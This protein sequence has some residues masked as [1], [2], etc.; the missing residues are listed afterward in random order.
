MSL[1]YGLK[2]LSILGGYIA[3]SDRGRVSPRLLKINQAWR[4]PRQ[5]HQLSC[6]SPQK[7]E[8]Q[9]ASR[10]L[11]TGSRSYQIN[12]DLS[13]PATEAGSRLG[14]RL[15]FLARASK[16]SK[17]TRPCCLR[18]C[19]ALRANLRHAIQTAVRPNSL[20][21]LRSAQT[22]GRQSDHDARLS[23]GSLGRSLNHVPQAQPKGWE[24]TACECCDGFSSFERF[25]LL[26][27]Y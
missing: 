12:T 4:P 24:R 8:A 23:C 5:H 10:A 25:M 22:S 18:P 19:A 26:E 6:R 9:S 27:P 21:A 2:Q 15:P 3:A 13:S 11:I 14:W 16:G 17:R 7:L 20:H 1:V